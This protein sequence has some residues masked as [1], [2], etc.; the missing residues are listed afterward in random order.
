MKKDISG[1]SF[2]NNY[3]NLIRCIPYLAS[4]KVYSLLKQLYD[5]NH[6]IM[7]TIDAKI[8]DDNILDTIDYGIIEYISRY[9]TSFG[10]NIG[11]N[12]VSGK[13][14]QIFCKT[15]KKLKDIKAFPEEHSVELM[16]IIQK[17]EEDE[18]SKI[19]FN[20]ESNVDLLMF[21]TLNED[22]AKEVLNIKTQDKK[23]L[24]ETY[25]EK[26]KS[27]SRAEI[28]S[29]Y[30]NKRK[31]LNAIGKRFFN[32]SYTKMRDL[33]DKYG[34]DYIVFL[35][36]LQQKSRTT[37]LT[38]EEEN[39]LKALLTLRNINELL[40]IEDVDALVRVF[41]E[42]DGE[43]EYKE[44][45]FLALT[46]L[47]EE[48]KK[49]YSKDLIENA[50]SIKEEDKVN[51]IDG[52]KIYS[53]KRF[54]MFVSV[55][56]AF[57]D[58]QLVNGEIS[59]K[60]IWNSPNN[61]K[62]NHLLCTSFIGNMNLCY[63]RKDIENSKDNK[64]DETVIFGFGKNTKGY[65]A[66]ASQSDIGS[67]TT[68]MSSEES[69]YLSKFRTSENIMKYCRHGHNEVDFERRLANDGLQNIE[70]EYIVCFDTI[71]ENSKKV[72]KD[73]GIPI[74]LINKR[75]IAK[76]QNKD[77]ED[78]IKLFK[79]TREP[80]LLSDIINMYQCSR[81]SFLVGKEEKAL[82]DE[83]F[84]ATKINSTLREIMNIIEKERNF[85]DKNNANSCYL[86][87]FRALNEEMQLFKQE[88]KDIDTISEYQTN[89][90]KIMYELKQIID[91]NNI[92]KES[93]KRQ[94]ESLE[95]K[96]YKSIVSERNRED[97]AR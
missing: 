54:K 77:L 69:F 34:T 43:E 1:E 29:K 51:E 22:S 83:F 86:E 27:D 89:F 64:E 2:E 30:L 80:E 18:F 87:L 36:E 10:N 84:S 23:D 71:N 76:Q 68:N 47:D 26:I 32:Y 94:E 41:D 28:H 3:Y 40:E 21:L 93:N 16:H 53:P 79:E 85:G 5:S 72:A 45:D 38:L 56:G 67:D 31:A 14:L 44:I 19:N 50:Y 95:D 33:K 66:M 8:L 11:E 97:V 81:I 92:N 88:F 39:R 63:V 74:V 13:R 65:I 57:N 59:S 60:E 17:I 42:L 6:N 37:E 62:K 20:D 82:A 9:G 35:K 24:F 61:N 48:M 46:T 90:R 15:F 49:I 55:I 4:D 78:K 75:E 12:E 7:K 25:K 52:I 70:P 91:K 58:Y 96:M 73:F